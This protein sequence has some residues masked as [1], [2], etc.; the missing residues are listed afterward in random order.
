MFADSNKY[1]ILA[2]SIKTKYMARV[3]TYRV[4]CMITK[5]SKKKGSYMKSS[6]VTDVRFPTVEAAQDFI[7]TAFT[8]VVKLS[9]L[10]FQMPGFIAPV[11][12]EIV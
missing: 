9:E 6:Y 8:N 4:K 3:K 5:Y 7:K 10:R 2:L 11:F 12:V 1:P